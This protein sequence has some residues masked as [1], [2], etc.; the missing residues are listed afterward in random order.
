MQ[1]TLDVLV[2]PFSNLNSENP[3][4]FEKPEF[5]KNEAVDRLLSQYN[6]V[7]DDDL[8]EL[9]YQGIKN[10]IRFPSLSPDEINFLMQRIFLKYA[11][12]KI[13]MPY[14]GIFISELINESENYELNLKPLDFNIEFL[15]SQIK[16]PYWRPVDMPLSMTLEGNAANGFGYCCHEDRSNNSWLYRPELY[17]LVKGNAQRAVGERARNCKFVIEG[18]AANSFG[19]MSRFSEFVVNGDVGDNCGKLANDSKFYIKGNAGDNLGFWSKE[20]EYI[21]EGRVGN[22]IGIPGEKRWRK[23]YEAEN[24]TFKTPNKET[25]KKLRKNLPK[26]NKAIFMPEKEIRGLKCKQQQDWSKKYWLL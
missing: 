23:P 22:F 1:K 6:P 8:I 16:K 10:K 25:Y 15:C 26:G 5:E 11:R 9:R 12:D 19:V 17:F 20:C 13:E 21:V 24:C 4:N 14:T 3:D 2:N 7:Y 18:N